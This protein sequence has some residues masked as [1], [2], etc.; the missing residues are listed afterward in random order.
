M[1]SKQRKP[2]TK[3]ILHIE[4]IDEVCNSIINKLKNDVAF[5]LRFSRCA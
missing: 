5:K 2:F 1:S 4:N 3:D